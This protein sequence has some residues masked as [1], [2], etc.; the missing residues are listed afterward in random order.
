MH[1]VSA[2]RNRVSHKFI[3]VDIGTQGRS[4][5][6]PPMLEIEIGTALLRVPPDFPANNLV[7]L[8]CALQKGEA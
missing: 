3:A 5:T 2:P 7:G 6:P 1:S 8:V 4:A